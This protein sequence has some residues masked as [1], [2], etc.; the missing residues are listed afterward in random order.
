MK[1]KKL[2]TNTQADDNLNFILETATYTK[3]NMQS[4]FY[5]YALFANLLC[6]VQT[7]LIC[8]KKNNVPKKKLLATKDV[9]EVFAENL[10]DRKQVVVSQP[11]IR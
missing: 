7:G 11:N 6:K 10:M 3:K 4:I 8:F 5:K 1:C 9:I 2:K